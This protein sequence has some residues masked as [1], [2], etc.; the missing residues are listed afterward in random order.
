MISR[1]YHD[2]LINIFGQ[3]VLLLLWQQK[4]IF[5]KKHVHVIEKMEFGRKKVRKTDPGLPSLLAPTGALNVMV[6]YY[7]LSN[8]QIFE[9]SLSASI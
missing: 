3:T 6:C 8:V 1:Q 2:I 7:R 5:N 4:K 9:F